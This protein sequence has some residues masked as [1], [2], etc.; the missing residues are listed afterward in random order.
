MLGFKSYRSAAV[1]LTVRLEPLRENPPMS[2]AEVVVALGRSDLKGNYSGSPT[3]CINARN[4]RLGR[5]TSH[6]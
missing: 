4:S 5:K 2:F 6:L 3:R 1:T